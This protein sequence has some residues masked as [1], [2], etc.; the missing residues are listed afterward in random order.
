MLIVNYA[1][2]CFVTIFF[3]FVGVPVGENC[4]FVVE[5][6]TNHFLIVKN[7]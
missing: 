7:R 6:L 2:L 3:N 4:S 5:I 1:K